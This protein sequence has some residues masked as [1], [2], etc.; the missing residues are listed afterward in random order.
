MPSPPSA[1]MPLSGSGDRGARRHRPGA[2]LGSSGRARV[3]RPGG[4]GGRGR[5]RAADSRPGGVR[6]DRLRPG[7]RLGPGR[8]GPGPLRGPDDG[9]VDD[10]G[11]ADRRGRADRGPDGSAA[12]SG[13]RAG[14]PDRAAGRRD[15]LPLRARPAGRPPERPGRAGPRRPRLRQRRR[16]RDRAGRC[17]PAV[18]ARGRRRD[19]AARGAVRPALRPAA[20]P[21]GRRAGRR[22][23]AVAGRGP[24]GGG[25]CQPDHRASCTCS[26]A[27]R[28]R[29]P[30]WQP[31]RPRR[32]RWR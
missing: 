31:A 7:H 18:P 4:H 6:R 30:R 22:T 24:G 23:D 25:Q 27:G 5:G 29:P 26:W 21:A 15:Q 28:A 9:P 13:A 10:P 8:D 14:H 11:R 20:L 19:L 12:S 16:H 2:R 3:P 32:C 17:G 1:R